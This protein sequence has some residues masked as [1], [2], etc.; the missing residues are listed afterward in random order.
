MSDL[1]IKTSRTQAATSNESSGPDSGLRTLSIRTISGAEYLLPD[2]LPDHL[3]E[4]RTQFSVGSEQ[5]LVR[6]V[7]GATMIV[8]LRII[9]RCSILRQDDQQGAGMEIW[10]RE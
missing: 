10:R 8:P 7:S 9:K 4:V 1:G 5:I 3:E 6:N 2:L